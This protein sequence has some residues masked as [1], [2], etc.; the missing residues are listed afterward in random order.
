MQ[1][2]NLCDCEVEQVK[3]QFWNIF[4]CGFT[5]FIQYEVAFYFLCLSWHQNNFRYVENECNF[6]W[7]FWPSLNLITSV[8]KFKL[9]I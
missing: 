8:D 3:C 9:K 6:E 1:L 7:I 4:G 5:I 2:Q